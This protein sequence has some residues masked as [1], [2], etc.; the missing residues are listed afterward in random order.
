M[1][2]IPAIDLQDGRCV[3]LFQGDFEQQ[4]VYSD[5]PLQVSYN[6]QAMGLHDLHVVDLDGA[7]DGAQRNSAVV[8]KIAANADLSIQ[9]GGGIRSADTFRYWLDR[10]VSRCVVGSMA[11]EEPATVKSWLRHFGPTRTALALDVRISAN[12]TPLLATH[13]WTRTTQASLWDCVA[14][15]LE[16][17]LTRVLC[18]DIS[19]DGALS[20]PNLDL[21]RMFRDRFPDIELQASGGVRSS[22]DLQAL[23]DIG[24]QSAITGRALLDGRIS[25]VELRKFLPAA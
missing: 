25:D 16:V 22:A 21:Y 19:R 9:L 4:K 1:Q 3:R 20:G 18:T 12:G 24:V 14:S 10:G 8:Q 2:L 17:G 15:Y 13:G 23:R 5:D 11:V 7:K 6:F